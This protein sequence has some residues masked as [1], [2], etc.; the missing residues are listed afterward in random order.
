V[1][2]SWIA[3][4]AIGPPICSYPSRPHASDPNDCTVRI[5]AD[6]LRNSRG[7]VGILLFNSPGGWPEDV[8]KAYRHEANPIA[9]GAHATTVTF[10]GIPPGD[11]GVVALHDENKNMRLD[12][13]IFG[14]P[15]EG[16]GFANNPHVGLG[17]PAFHSAVLHV[18]CPMTETTIHIVYK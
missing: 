18:T 17:P 5:Q 8:T 12:R 3:I 10:A 14:W 13:N 1:R 16:F 6:G 9:A 4:L 15:K 2:A 7:V 11:Y